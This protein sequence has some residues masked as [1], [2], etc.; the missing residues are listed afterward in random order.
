MGFIIKDD[1]ETGEYLPRTHIVLF[2]LENFTYPCVVQESSSIVWINRILALRRNK[3]I[4]LPIGSLT[5]FKEYHGPLGDDGCD[6]ERG[7]D[8]DEDGAEGEAEVA[9]VAADV[10]VLVQGEETS[11]RPALLLPEFKVL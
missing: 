10:T 3:S 9:L 6:D 8:D 2:A 11:R 4:N 7:E 1:L 5:Q